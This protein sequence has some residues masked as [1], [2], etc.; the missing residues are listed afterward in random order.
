MI[1][2]KVKRILKSFGWSLFPHH[3]AKRHLS[4]VT[5]A[6][7]EEAV[8]PLFLSKT[9]ECVDVGA[10][11]GRYTVLMSLC[12]QHVHAFD[13]NPEC[14]NTLENLCL[15]NVSIYPCALSSVEGSSEYFVP[16]R[17]G[18]PFSVWGTLERS[19]LEKHH[20]VNTIEVSKSTLDLLCDRKISLVKIDVEGHEMDV[21]RGGRKLISEQKPIFIVEAE[22]RH[23]NDAVQQVKDFFAQYHYQGFFI[24]DQKVFPLTSF[25][26]QYQNPQELKRPVP[27]IQMR[28]V[29]NFIFIPSSSNIKSILQKASARLGGMTGHL[30]L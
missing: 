27:R 17:Q 24:L 15:P 30:Q 6:E 13:P 26:Y 8:V 28:Y 5:G 10:N 9:T 11:C 4:I 2:E 16:I 14:I 20:E 18:L 1:L 19:V 3:L 12:S 29:N 22:E 25:D 23:C 7:I 21:L